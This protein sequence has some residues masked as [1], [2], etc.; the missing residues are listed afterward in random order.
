[1]E[2]IVRT[3]IRHNGRRYTPGETVDLTAEQAGAV[4][5]AIQV[6]TQEAP[7][8]AVTPERVAQPVVGGVS[9][10]LGEPS[11]DGDSTPPTEAEDVTPV[12]SERMKRDELEAA[13][14]EQGIPQEEI[15]A[16]PNKAALVDIIQDATEPGRDPSE[17]L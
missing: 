8:P 10:E 14:A 3:N 9:V 1:M 15:E 2:Y 13:A 11:I 12:V 4:G 16:A 17:S 7:E 5:D 6:G